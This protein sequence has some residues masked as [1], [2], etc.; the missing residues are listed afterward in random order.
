M[1]KRILLSAGA[2]ATLLLAACENTNE[3]PLDC[4]EVFNTVT[5]TRGDTVVLSTGTR[6]IETQV[7]TGATVVACRVSQ[8]RVRG[9]LLNGTEF[10]EPVL[11]PTMPGFQ[12]QGRLIEGMDHGIVG[13]RVG[14]KRRLIIPP[15]LGYG[16]EDLIRGGE[17]VIP[18]NSTIVFD[19]E[20]LA[21]QD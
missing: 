16:A 7:G 20:A 19:V 14:G 21:V 15:A 9:T 17:V 18:G 4:D 1:F 6:Y 2:G 3:P 5:E 13:M 10:Q 8:I 11:I 12:G